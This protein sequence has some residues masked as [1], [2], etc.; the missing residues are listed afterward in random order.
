MKRRS[1]APRLQLYLG[2]VTLLLSSIAT[3][4]GEPAR[5]NL[6]IWSEYIDPA[7]VADF[8]KANDCKVVVDLYE[9]ESGMMA[10]LQAGGASLYD[11]VVPPDHK[12][13]VMI[14]LGLLAPLRHANIPNLKNLDAKFSNPAYDPGNRYSVAY[15]WGTVGILT[16]QTKIPDPSWGLLFDEKLQP[17]GFVL[18]DS[19]RDLIG[20]ALMYRGH[21]I[22][23]GVPAELKEARDLL[24]ASKKRCVGMDGSV[25]GKNRVLGGGAVAAIVYSGEAARAIREDPKLHYVLPKEGTQVWVDN[26][27][28]LAQ[29]PHRDLAER[30]INFLLDPSNG[31]RIS[32]FTQFAT[33][34]HASKAQIKPEGLANPAIYP[35]ESMSSKL[36]FLEDLGT[37][38][39]LYDEVWTHIKSK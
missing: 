11:V 30:F 4:A 18:I 24:V 13:P 8:E 20:A 2:L 1:H 39:R 14:K 38:S 17:G 22:N 31:A 28:V 19:A 6:F 35:P 37:K 21:S 16:R 7:V 15:Q 36:Q 34:N 29:A 27:A 3:S 32:N 5:L 12:V 9:D 25:G 10:K 26:L 23:S 33:P